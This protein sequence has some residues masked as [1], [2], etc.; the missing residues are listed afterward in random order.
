MYFLPVII[1]TD[2]QNESVPE[3]LCISFPTGC[4]PVGFVCA[5]IATLTSDET[6]E[7]LGKEQA[8]L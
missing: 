3:P 5:L 2:Q 7:L 6:F 4:L 1:N 8:R